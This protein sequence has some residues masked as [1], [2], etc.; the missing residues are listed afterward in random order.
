MCDRC[1]ELE[2]RIEGLL[3]ELHDLKVAACRQNAI[4][5]AI[6]RWVPC[7]RRT[8]QDAVS[9]RDDYQ[10]GERGA[11]H[12]TMCDEIDALRL[13]VAWLERIAQDR[14]EENERLRARF[15]YKIEA[16]RTPPT[17]ALSGGVETPARISAPGTLA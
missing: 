13:Q 5:D 12:Y 9:A 6:V 15:I 3:D 7:L 14:G 16:E 11:Q 17:F 10:Y 4:D 2:A 8:G 1:P